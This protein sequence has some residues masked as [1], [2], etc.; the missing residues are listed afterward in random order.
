[1]AMA[2]TANAATPEPSTYGM[3]AAGLVCMAVFL[4]HRA[5]RNIKAKL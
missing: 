3:M 2:G 5:T 1:M 4:R